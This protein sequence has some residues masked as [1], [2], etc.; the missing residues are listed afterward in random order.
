MTTY[1]LTSQPRSTGWLAF[2]GGLG[3]FFYTMFFAAL[4]LLPVLS[5][6][7]AA[8]VTERHQAPDVDDRGRVQNTLHD[9]SIYRYSDAQGMVYMKG[10]DAKLAETF[11]VRYLAFMP[12]V[13]AIVTETTPY[14]GAAYAFGAILGL[15]AAGQGARWLFSR[16]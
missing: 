4:L 2:V 7:A 16:T 12:S 11:R 5:V 13:S 6:E 1:A 9:V 14:E 10:V 15:A 8:V 3:V